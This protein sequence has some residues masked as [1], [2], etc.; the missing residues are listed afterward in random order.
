MNSRYILIALGYKSNTTMVFAMMVRMHT[1]R[2]GDI[3][4]SDV[5]SSNV[6]Y[7]SLSKNDRLVLLDS[8][9]DDDAAF[10]EMRALLKTDEPV[11]D[12]HARIL[13]WIQTFTIGLNTGAPD[14]TVE[15]YR[16]SGKYGTLERFLAT[17]NGAG[18]GMDPDTVVYVNDENGDEIMVTVGRDEDKRVIPLAE[19]RAADEEPVLMARLDDGTTFACENG[20]KISPSDVG[21]DDA[22]F[23]VREF[24]R[25]GGKTWNKP[26]WIMRLPRD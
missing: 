18:F 7:S 26:T 12:A 6:R 9:G 25:D 8:T 13:G 4:M 21:G 15:R 23:R 10:L 5:T 11:S 17:L 3:I 16:R 14:V 22:W 20:K 24:S 1:H 19:Y 2:I